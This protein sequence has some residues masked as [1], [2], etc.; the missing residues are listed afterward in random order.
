MYVSQY[1]SS[2]DGDKNN[3]IIRLNFMKNLFRLNN[4]DLTTGWFLSQDNT[5]KF[6]CS[7]VSRSFAMDNYNC[8]DDFENW[9][10]I[11]QKI[12]AMF[13]YMERVTIIIVVKHG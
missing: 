4:C 3:L 1:L 10:I 7:P 9:L 6:Q 2:V 8:I 11:R 13:R 5:K 12:N